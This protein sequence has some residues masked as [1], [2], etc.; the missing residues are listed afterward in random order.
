MWIVELKLKKFPSL[1]LEYNDDDI[2]L[3]TFLKIKNMNLL[4]QCTL[5]LQ[6]KICA[7]IS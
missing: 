5:R 2:P 1:N 4:E 6:D 7:E 3:I